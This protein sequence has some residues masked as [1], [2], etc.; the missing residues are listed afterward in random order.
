MARR[1]EKYI[2]PPCPPE[3]LF[4]WLVSGERTV[5]RVRDDKGAPALFVRCPHPRNGQP[6]TRK[7]KGAAALVTGAVEELMK[8]ERHMQMYPCTWTMCPRRL[9]EIG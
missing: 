9:E 5:Q 2:A 1:V 6:A 4:T 3:L 8:D 7:N